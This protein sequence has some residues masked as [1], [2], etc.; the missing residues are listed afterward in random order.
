MG[1][2]IHLFAEAKNPETGEWEIVPGPVVTCWRCDGTGTFHGELCYGCNKA[3]HLWQYIDEH[4]EEISIEQPNSRFVDEPGKAREAWYD[5]RN[6]YVFACLADVRNHDI[7]F[8]KDFKGYTVSP[9]RR[10]SPIIDEPR[11]LPEGVTKEAHD[12][13]ADDVDI[14]SVSWIGLEEIFAFTWPA[15]EDDHD[16]SAYFMEHMKLLA[17]TAGERPT[18]IV[19]GFDN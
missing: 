16:R 17:I 15:S 19:F 12:Y 2:D 10:Y 6:Y 5:E 13:L 11:G 18:R 4:G 9:F 14:H 8:T 3:S 7:S 1:C